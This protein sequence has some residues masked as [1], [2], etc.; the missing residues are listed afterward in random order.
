MPRRAAR[1]KARATPSM[2]AVNEGWRCRA[3]REGSAM[4][5]SA[6]GGL[7]TG[8]VAQRRRRVLVLAVLTGL[9]LPSA[10]RAQ[11][12]YDPI[13]PVNRAIFSFNMTADRYVLE[14]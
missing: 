14:P 1:L 8:P 5:D 3:A 9:L 13:E 7:R 6:G 2:C 12:V 11:E 4:S 10:L